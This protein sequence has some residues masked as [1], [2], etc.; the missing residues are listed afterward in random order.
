MRF[1]VIRVL[2]V[3]RTFRPGSAPGVVEL[4]RNCGLGCTCSATIFNAVAGPKLAENKC[5]CFNDRTLQGVSEVPGTAHLVEHKAGVQ[6]FEVSA[7]LVEA[8]R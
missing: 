1:E 3:R 4:E 2:K 8:R 7:E 5:M 6:V